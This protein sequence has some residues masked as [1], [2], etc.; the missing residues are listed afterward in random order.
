MRINDFNAR[1]GGVFI[2]AN[3]ARLVGRPESPC[4]RGQ[5]GHQQFDFN[6]CGI[7]F[8]GAGGCVVSGACPAG[9]LICG[10]LRGVGF[11]GSIL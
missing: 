9:G 4:G 7:F 1:W 11:C 10:I 6:G 3:S 8:G 2:K 5:L